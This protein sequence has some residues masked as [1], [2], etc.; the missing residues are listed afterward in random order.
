MI[1]TERLP[2]GYWKATITLPWPGGPDYVQ[3]ESSFHDEQEAT[4]WAEWMVGFLN[5]GRALVVVPEQ[6]P[7]GG[8]G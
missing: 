5:D 3:T 2:N 6:E 4:D 8:E 7:T 1:A